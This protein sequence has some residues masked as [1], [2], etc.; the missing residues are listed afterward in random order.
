MCRFAAVA[1]LPYI[2]LCVERHVPI[3]SCVLNLE[4]VCTAV[5]KCL[6]TLNFICV[7]KSYFVI[8]LSCFSYLICL[9]KVTAI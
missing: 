5:L 4:T 9:L 7:I 3:L 8:V 2:A 6:V 1:G